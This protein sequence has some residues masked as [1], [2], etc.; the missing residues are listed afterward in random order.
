MT[1]H[2]FV[3]VLLYFSSQ[4]QVHFIHTYFV[5]VKIPKLREK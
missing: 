5:T 4:A 2:I 1:P 3:A